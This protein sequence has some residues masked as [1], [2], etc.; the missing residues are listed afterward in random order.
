MI[1]SC[2]PWK[3]EHQA[4]KDTLFSENLG[5][6]LEQEH[7][8]PKLGRKSK[9]NAARRRLLRLFGLKAV[10]YRETRWT[11]VQSTLSR[12]YIN[13]TN[14][15]FPSAPFASWGNK[16]GHVP[17]VALGTGRRSG[18]I[19]AEIETLNGVTGP[20]IPSSL[21]VSPSTPVSASGPAQHMHVRQGNPPVGS[22]TQRAQLGIGA[23]AGT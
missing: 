13:F 18:S 7:G 21:S 15:T 22:D 2:R 3:G 20:F 16:I 4:R 14:T 23:I 19:D 9:L 17:R 6:K 5:W 11:H 1:Q 10:T 12:W 8:A